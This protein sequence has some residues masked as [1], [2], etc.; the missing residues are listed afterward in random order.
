MYS[1]RLTRQLKKS[2][3]DV[4]PR[5][6]AFASFL[7]MIDEAYQQLDEKL[8]SAQRNLTVSSEELTSANSKL[9]QLN[10][11]F[12]AMINSLGQGFLLFGEDLTCLNVASKACENLLECDPA[13]RRIQDVLHISGDEG[14]DFTNWCKM[15]FDERIAFEDMAALGP[16]RFAHSDLNRN[17]VLEYKPC[18]DR[19]GKITA[20][21]MVATDKTAEFVARK[22]AAEL[23]AHV[24]MITN[25]LK[26]KNRFRQFIAEMRRMSAELGTI[27]NG[28]KF[29][30]QNLD[31]AKRLLHTMKGV[32][33][34]FGLLKVKMDCHEAET[35]LTEARTPDIQLRVLR[36]W[37]EK[38]K[39]EF[40]S[41][42]ESNRELI[43]DLGNGESKREIESSVL[44]G[45]LNSI[46]SA[47][48]PQE[49]ALAYRVQILSV[50]LR[51]LL[52]EFDSYISEM[53][54]HLGKRVSPLKFA[55]DDP[56][57]L[58]EEVRPLVSAFPHILSNMVDHGIE[59]EETR[60]AR[61]KAAAGSIEVKFEQNPEHLKI[62]ISDDGK[63]IDVPTLRMKLE[64]SGEHRLASEGSDAEVMEQIFRPGISTAKNVSEFSGRGVGMD[65][66]RSEIRKLGGNISVKSE[67][68]KGTSF[69]IELPTLGLPSSARS[70]A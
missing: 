66:V 10:Q 27:A 64:A 68:G 67:P 43:G 30:S 55:G 45:F 4:A 63:G 13:G 56:R 53:A 28:R 9:Y 19:S 2:F 69:Y 59:S 5:D 21:V 12:D 37:G 25:I 61:G 51:K 16:A 26:N 23:A 42:I 62:I 20:I 38:I 70:A 41:L 33:G 6:E 40:E 15:M 14:E 31:E 39:S 46:L 48:T 54:S 34:A 35:I 58:E 11:S 50:P 44:N 24:K 60:L 29:S 52:F 3:G 57:V 47:S 17:V 36:D 32:A 65:S 49:I 8:E 22:E 18:R 1:K 7:S